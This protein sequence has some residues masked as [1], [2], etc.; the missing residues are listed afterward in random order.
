M[1]LSDLNLDTAR[2][3]ESENSSD[4][5]ASNIKVSERFAIKSVASARCHTDNDK[6]IN[7]A[8]AIPPFMFS[9]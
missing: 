6:H 8:T 7:A 4:F 9:S 5:A 2:I 3:S 1:A